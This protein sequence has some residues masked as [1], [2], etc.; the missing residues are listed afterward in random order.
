VYDSE[1]SYLES[2][3]YGEL[4][5]GRLGLGLSGNLNLRG[6]VD[7]HVISSVRHPAKWGIESDV[8]LAA[9]RSRTRKSTHF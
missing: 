2:I 9:Q 5:L 7:L 8:H 3:L 4:S 1:K 6:I